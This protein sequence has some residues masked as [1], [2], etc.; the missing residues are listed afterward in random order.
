MIVIK[1]SLRSATPLR[2]AQGMYTSGYT[3]IFTAIETV[4]LRVDKLPTPTGG[5]EV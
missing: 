2:E 1:D 3:F 4:R 5:Q